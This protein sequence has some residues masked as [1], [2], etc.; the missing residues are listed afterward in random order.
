M[1]DIPV[2]GIFENAGTTNGDAKS[3]QDDILAILR[4]IQ[5]GAAR[6]TLTI[7][8]GV[9]TPTAYSHAID[10]EGGIPSDDLDTIAVTNMPDGRFLMLRITNNARAVVLVNGAGGTGELILTGAA[11]FNMT[12]TEYYIILQRIGTQW[13]EQSRGY[14]SD[15]TALRAFIGLGG[16]ATL[17]VGTGLVSTG[18]NLNVDV[19]GLTNLASGVAVDDELPLYDLSGS[20]LMRVQLQVLLA[21]I[22]ALTE[23]ISPDLSNDFLMSYDTSA[24]GVKKIRLSAFSGVPTGT[25]LDYAGTTAPSGFLECD[26]SAVSRATY[27]T[28]FN[29]IGTTWGGGDGVNTFNLP[30]FA[31]RT[32]IGRGGTG[33]TTIGNAVGNVGGEESHALTAA[34]NGPHSHSSSVG[35]PITPGSDFDSNFVWAGGPNDGAGWDIHTYSANIGTSGSGTSHNTMQPSAVVMKVIKV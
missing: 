13:I 18:G 29:K 23:D 16:A 32:T 1:T 24:S 10:T 7:A 15:F 17:G 22:N 33:T 27:S 14:G 5:G 11:N 6:T 3:A 25:V 28:L 30:N 20:A 26:G 4:E 19:H 9:V 35:L 12:S 31:R 21:V 34:E 2:A 8:T